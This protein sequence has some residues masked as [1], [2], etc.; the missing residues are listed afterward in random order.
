MTAWEAKILRGLHLSGQRNQE[1]ENLRA[2][3]EKSWREESWKG[4]LLILCTNL[5]KSWSCIG[6]QTHQDLN[7]HINHCPSPR[8]ALEQWKVQKAWQDLW[9]FTWHQN[10]HKTEYEVWPHPGWLPPKQS[11]RQTDQ[12]SPKDFNRTQSLTTWYSKRAGYN[13]KL[14]DI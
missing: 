13:P 3:W 5:H 4:Q 2:G 1:K 9:K 14:L 10:H 11:N 6:Q 8:L 7:Y 12:Y